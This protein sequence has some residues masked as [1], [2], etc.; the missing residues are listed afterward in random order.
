MS[1]AHRSRV[2]LRGLWHLPARPGICPPTTR[3]GPWATFCRPRGRLCK[4][5]QTAPSVQVLGLL[6]PEAVGVW[7][8]RAIKGA[9]RTRSLPSAGREDRAAGTRGGCFTSASSRH[10]RSKQLK[11][12]SHQN[13]QGDEPGAGSRER[14]EGGG[15]GHTGP[16]TQRW[17]PRSRHCLGPRAVTVET[18]LFSFLKKGLMFEERVF[19]LYGQ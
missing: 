15:P 12:K 11:E 6:S 14:R 16:F 7:S 2:T 17:Q 9:T 18:R 5:E 13:T 4:E 8:Q 3:P 1:C 10:V 19:V